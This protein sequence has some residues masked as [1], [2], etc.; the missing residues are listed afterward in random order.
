MRR[1]SGGKLSH[2]SWS[3]SVLTNEVVRDKPSGLGGAPDREGVS[4]PALGRSLSLDDLAESLV[5]VLA[6][7]G[8]RLSVD[9]AASEFA[10]MLEGSDIVS[11][12]RGR[13][14]YAVKSLFSRIHRLI[15][16]RRGSVRVVRWSSGGFVS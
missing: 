5:G 4:R 6:S 14:D 12:S 3:T 16:S 13:T 9:N 7:S 1:S 10:G 8:A 15:C 11:S 2:S